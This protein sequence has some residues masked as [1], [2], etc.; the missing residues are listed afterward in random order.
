MKVRT[1]IQNRSIN[2][3]NETALQVGTGVRA[4]P[5]RSRRRILGSAV[6]ATIAVT[7]LLGTMTLRD[8][9]SSRSEVAPASPAAAQTEG[10]TLA[11]LTQTWAAPDAGSLGVELP[12]AAAPVPAE[13]T[14][15]SD[16]ALWAS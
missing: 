5:R 1:N 10:P 3:H 16:A 9:D 14:A 15:A 4:R 2:N 7:G 11:E 6:I 8:R 13:P 12:A